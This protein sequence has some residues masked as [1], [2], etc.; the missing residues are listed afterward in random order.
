MCLLGISNGVT[1]IPSFRQ[2]RVPTGLSFPIKS[3]DV[4]AEVQKKVCSW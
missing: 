2:L 1:L 4:I 3:R